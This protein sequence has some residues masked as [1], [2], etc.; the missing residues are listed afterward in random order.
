MKCWAPAAAGAGAGAGNP[1]HQQTF[2]FT[3]HYSPG[4]VLGQLGTVS[5]QKSELSL[6]MVCAA[7]SYYS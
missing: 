1:G 2:H 6:V 3:V 4:W 5:R 7:P